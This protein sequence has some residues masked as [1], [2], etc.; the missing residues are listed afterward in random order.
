MKRYENFYEEENLFVDSLFTLDKNQCRGV[1]LQQQIPVNNPYDEQPGIPLKGDNLARMVALRSG[2]TMQN[3]ERL[4]DDMIMYGLIRFGM[5]NIFFFFFFFSFVF[6]FKMNVIK[7]INVIV[8]VLENFTMINIINIFSVILIV[9][10][11]INVW[12]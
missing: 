5:F 6:V 7:K 1:D 8:I 2:G 9:Y 10:Y 11:R 12:I 3:V 4:V